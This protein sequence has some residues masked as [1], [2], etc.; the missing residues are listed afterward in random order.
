MKKTFLFLLLM[1]T[2]LLAGCQSQTAAQATGTLHIN[3]TWQTDAWKPYPAVITNLP[4]TKVDVYRLF[5]SE[6]YREGVTDLL[7]VYQDETLPA[8]WYWVKAV[9]QPEGVKKSD[10]GKHWVANFVHI[11]PGKITELDFGYENAGGWTFN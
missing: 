4:D 10:Y 2:L 9:H 7:G 8:G 1:L 11:Q 3:V 5:S 6:V